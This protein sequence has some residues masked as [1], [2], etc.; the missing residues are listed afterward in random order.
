MPDTSIKAIR[1]C[2][3]GD[4]AFFNVA[5]GG[6][7]LISPE[8]LDHLAGK[9]WTCVGTGIKRYMHNRER[10]GDRRPV[11]SMHRVIMGA[12]KQSRLTTLTTMGL[13]IAG[14]IFASRRLRSTL[15]TGASDQRIASG[16]SA[17]GRCGISP[18]RST[19]RSY[20]ETTS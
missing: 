9:A 19:G 11:V 10:V 7:C 17:C 18:A 2:T 13:T 1:L 3:C 20:A 12:A 6:V 15:R 4:H 16:I 8:D 14:P 5:R